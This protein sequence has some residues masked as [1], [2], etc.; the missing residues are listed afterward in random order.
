MD[1]NSSLSS[2]PMH[3]AALLLIADDSAL[4][5]LGSD[6]ASLISVVFSVLAVEAFINELA[7]PWRKKNDRTLRKKFEQL[8]KDLN[9]P[10][11][12]CND[13]LM[14]NRT[15][16]AL[17]HFRPEVVDLDESQS[18]FIPNKVVQD[19]V[20]RKVIGLE[21]GV[22]PTLIATLRR[23][24]VEKWANELARRVIRESVLRLPAT[25]LKDRELARWSK[26]PSPNP[27]IK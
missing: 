4:G 19:L 9:L 24:E 15:R 12:L 27:V 22:M 21:S 23:P 10:S 8:S 5:T 3:S 13:F 17:V 14:L 7:W 25:P 11:D 18:A 20:D 6:Q 26:I 16:N 2:Q 1:F